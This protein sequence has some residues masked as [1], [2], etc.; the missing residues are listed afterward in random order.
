MADPQETRIPQSVRILELAL[1][2]RMAADKFQERGINQNNLM[3]AAGML[4]EV[5]GR[6]M[7]EEAAAKMVPCG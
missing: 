2:V 6:L 5:A 1:Q 7:L 3:N 4:A